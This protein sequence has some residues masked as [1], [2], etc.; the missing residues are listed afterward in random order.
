MANVP[1]MDVE[2]LTLRRSERIAKLQQSKEFNVVNKTKKEPKKVNDANQT[3]LKRAI[4]KKQSTKT[5]KDK[6]KKAIDC[7][8]EA[9]DLS[10]VKINH[11]FTLIKKYCP[12]EER[13]VK[14]SILQTILK[15]YKKIGI[16]NTL[17]DLTSN[18]QKV[19]RYLSSDYDM[20]VVQDTL[21]SLLSFPELMLLSTQNQTSQLSQGGLDELI[22]MMANTNITSM[23]TTIDDD[24][25]A[26]FA[27]CHIG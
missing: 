19:A 23:N 26:L 18:V 14:Y 21:T 12:S 9:E 10:K 2:M 20:V 7:L 6:C 15:T 4:K 24:L 22:G 27:G 5:C 17:Q 13:T 11:L 3:K 8:R 16:K 1:S 25:T